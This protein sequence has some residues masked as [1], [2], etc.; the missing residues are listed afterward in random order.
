M[1]IEYEVQYICYERDAIVEKIRALWWVCTQERTFYK[2]VVYDL[3]HLG[4]SAFF[5]V[6]DEGDKV[7]CAV[8]RE[9]MES[10][11]I[12]RIEEVE[13][14]VSDYDAMREIASLMGVK[15]RQYQESYREKRQIGEVEV[16]FDERP[17]LPVV[18]EVESDSEEKV[19]DMSQQL[20]FDYDA[21]GMF[22]TI[23]EVYE[24]ELGMTRADV[25]GIGELVFGSV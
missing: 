24:K 13:V 22:G 5:R 10:I 21:D 9:N 14:E 16:V 3:P 15:E 23:Y 6:R 8:K 18:I 25:D 7:T 2:R 4:K 20:W 11:S 19:R 1:Q 17:L 12:D